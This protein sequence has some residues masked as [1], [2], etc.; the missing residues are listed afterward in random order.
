MTPKA[1]TFAKVNRS[2][3][4]VSGQWLDAK[5][6]NVT[7]GPETWVRLRYCFDNGQQVSL[8]QKDLNSLN[9]AGVTPRWV[10]Q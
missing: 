9:E 10:G 7:E 6:R 1:A 8:R 4:V 3:R 2:H 5:G